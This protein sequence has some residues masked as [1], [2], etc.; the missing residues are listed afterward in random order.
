MEVLV[1]VA[2]AR[3]EEEDAVVLPM[4]VMLAF[5]GGTEV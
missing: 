5:V 4:P 3:E 1:L 2:E